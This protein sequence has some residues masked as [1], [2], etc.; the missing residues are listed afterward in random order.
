MGLGTIYNF[1]FEKRKDKITEEGIKLLKEGHS[2]LGMEAE[3]P[4][5]IDKATQP[6][7][8]LYENMPDNEIGIIK[9]NWK[10]KLG[11]SKNSS[12]TLVTEFTSELDQILDD[13]DTEAKDML[14]V[15]D[16]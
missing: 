3:A 9:P 1:A 4:G 16:E 15:A 7:A 10:E 6:D 8:Y 14:E 12:S 13:L 2:I 5:I 11:L